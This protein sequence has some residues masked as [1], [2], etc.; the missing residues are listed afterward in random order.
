MSHNRSDLKQISFLFALQIILLPSLMLSITAIAFTIGIPITRFHFPLSLIL[1]VGLSYLLYRDKK[2]MFLKTTVLFIVIL[3]GCFIIS[4]MVYDFSFDGQVYH[5]PAVILLTSGWNPFHYNFLGEQRAEFFYAAE[6]VAPLIEHFT[7][8]SWIIGSGIYAFTGNLEGGKMF[9]F[10]LIIGSF[11]TALYFLFNLSRIGIKTK[12]LIALLA[13]FNPVCLYQIFSF[14]NDGLL[15]S[16]LTVLI[17]SSAAYI[18]KGERKALILTAA[19]IPILSNI[20][21]TGIIYG[22]VVFGLVC[23]WL[24]FRNRD[25]FKKYMLTNGIILI[26]SGV[27]LGYQPY[28]TNIIHKSNPFYPAIMF[29]KTS[30]GVVETIEIGQAPKNF[31]RKNRFIK[32][33]YSILSKTANQLHDSPELKIPFSLHKQEMEALGYTDARYGGFGP[34]FGGIILMMLVCGVITCRWKKR[35]LI[36][37]LTGMG[38]ILFS[39]LI[40]PESWWAR[41]SPQLWLLPVL[42]ITACF[43]TS[44]FKHINRYTAWIMIFILLVNCGVVV[45]AYLRYNLEM[46]G[47]Y[48]K[49]LSCMANVSSG[50][51]VEY[52]V[53][54][55]AVSL[56]LEYRLNSFGVRYRFMKTHNTKNTV[57]IK[58]TFGAVYWEQINDSKFK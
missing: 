11:M 55:S 42:F 17:M 46:N 58:G 20:K 4:T 13:A 39:I 3:M 28:I 12:L 9:H 51:N 27:F 41:L 31:L 22:G 10:L 2:G 1:T 7:K 43:Y 19:A 18:L 52:G 44:K 29:G 50:M 6:N 14:Y 49:Q 40:N 47:L 45:G 24:F 35:I 36:F 53:D 8:G 32:L 15:A 26:V 21:F 48:K 54:P 25:R 56:S 23:V 5:Q 16:M 33:G 38:F 37:F 30:N 34:L 57:P